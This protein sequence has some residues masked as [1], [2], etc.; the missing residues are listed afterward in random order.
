[1][2]GILSIYKEDYID[3]AATI[4]IRAMSG[5][6]VGAGRINCN[7]NIEVFMQDADLS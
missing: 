7:Y 4:A 1:M 5:N 2:G 3:S 6:T